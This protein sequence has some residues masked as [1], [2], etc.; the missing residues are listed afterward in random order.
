MACKR[1]AGVAAAIKFRNIL[2][3]IVALCANLPLNMKEGSAYAATT[4][5]VRLPYIDN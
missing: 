2:Q 1:L 5:G 3:K 4:L